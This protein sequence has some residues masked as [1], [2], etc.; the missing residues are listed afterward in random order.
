MIQFPSDRPDAHQQHVAGSQQAA[1][2]LI[3]HNCK[4]AAKRAARQSAMPASIVAVI[5]FGC[6]AVALVG[7]LASAWSG[8]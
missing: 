1:D 6:M 8:R 5:A 2:E 7:A 3:A 4:R